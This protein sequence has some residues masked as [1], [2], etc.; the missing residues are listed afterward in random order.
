MGD[1]RWSLFFKLFTMLTSAEIRKLA[2]EL[3]P[4]VREAVMEAHLVANDRVLTVSDVAEM[5]GYSEEAIRKRCRENRMPYTQKNGRYYFS[6]N[7][8]NEY[9]FNRK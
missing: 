8:I 9:Y 3:A 5:L 4:V 1:E 2:K 7:S 6:L